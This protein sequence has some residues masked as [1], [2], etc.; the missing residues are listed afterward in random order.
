M[1]G[2]VTGWF[3]ACQLS[4]SPTA[5]RYQQTPNTIGWSRYPRPKEIG[6]DNGSQFKGVFEELCKNMGLTPA[7]GWRRIIAMLPVRTLLYSSDL[8]KQGGW[9]TIEY[10]PQPNSILARIHQV[11]TVSL[12]VFI[13]EKSDINPD[14]DDPI[15]E[16]ISSVCHDI[17]SSYQQ[18]HGYSPMQLVFGGDVMADAVTSVDWDKIKCRKQKQIRR[19]NE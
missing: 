8:E 10:N 9:R 5:C 17:R 15:D 3:E 6:N 18:T 13:L 11:L 1:V 12:R 16:Y 2:P 19:N 14:D 4:G 7:R